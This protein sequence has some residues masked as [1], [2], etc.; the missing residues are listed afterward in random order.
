MRCQPVLVPISTCVKVICARAHAF[1]RRVPVGRSVVRGG[2][3]SSRP[4][5]A[6]WVC[7]RPRRTRVSSRVNRR[8]ARGRSRGRS[9]GRPHRAL[10]RADVGHQRRACAAVCGGCGLRLAQRLSSRTPGNRLTNRVPSA[11]LLVTRDDP[12]AG[13][14]SLLTIGVRVVTGMAC[15]LR[16]S[17]HNAQAPLLGLHPANR[18]TMTDTPTVE[19]ILQ[20]FPDVSLTIHKTAAGE[21]ILR[22]LTP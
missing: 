9:S 4:G 14:T 6:A 3:P 22:W 15:I 10:R 21:D 5:R 2:E 12:I 18:H 13:R 20:V 19:R 11:P 16:Q 1:Q 17:L 7:S 8:R